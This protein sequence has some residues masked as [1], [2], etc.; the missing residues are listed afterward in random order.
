MAEGFRLFLEDAVK[1]EEPDEE[2]TPRHISGIV[3]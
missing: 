2:V 1:D 3:L